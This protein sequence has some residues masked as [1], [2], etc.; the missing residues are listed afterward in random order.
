[1]YCIVYWTGNV[2]SVP[3]APSEKIQKKNK[4]N[5][6]YIASDPPPPNLMKIQHIFLK[7]LDH[8]WGTFAPQKGQNT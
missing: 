2:A 1:M 8:Y 5:I 4:C 6:C 7:K 3:K